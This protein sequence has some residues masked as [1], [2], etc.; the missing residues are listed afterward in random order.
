MRAIESLEHTMGVPATTV[1]SLLALSRKRNVSSYDVAGAVSEQEL[2]RMIR[3]AAELRLQVMEWLK[4]N[5]A[6]LLK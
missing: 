4:K 6:N 2:Q 1:H 5:H 3:I